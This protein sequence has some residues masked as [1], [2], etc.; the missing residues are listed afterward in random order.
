MRDG[1]LP[2]DVLLQD[3]D[4]DLMAMAMQMDFYWMD[5]AK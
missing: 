3:V 4:A 5:K 2:Y 1:Q